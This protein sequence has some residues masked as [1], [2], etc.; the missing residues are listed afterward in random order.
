MKKNN[1]A[2]INISGNSYG[3]EACNCTFDTMYGRT[4]TTNTSGAILGISMQEYEARKKQEEK[5]EKENKKAKMKKTIEIIALIIFSAVLSV[6]AV[7]AMQPM[8]L[9][10]SIVCAVACF[11][12]IAGRIVSIIESMS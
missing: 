11:G 3:Y 9:A 2:D 4:A 8:D 5:R 12:L 6:L 7:L 1:M 10:T